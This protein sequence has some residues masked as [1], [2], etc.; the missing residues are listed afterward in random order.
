MLVG[1]F[2]EDGFVADD[3]G[4]Y[5]TEDEGAAPLEGEDRDRTDFLIRLPTTFAELAEAHCED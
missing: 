1:E 3:D 2:G 5:E 4:V